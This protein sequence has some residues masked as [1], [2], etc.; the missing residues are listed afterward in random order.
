MGCPAL[1]RNLEGYFMNTFGRS[2]YYFQNVH[3]S[4]IQILQVCKYYSHYVNAPN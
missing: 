4:R 3:T 1:Q 2:V